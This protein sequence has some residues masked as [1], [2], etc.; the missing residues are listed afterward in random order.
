MFCD[1]KLPFSRTNG[2]KGGYMWCHPTPEHAG[3]GAPLS[4]LQNPDIICI[5]VWGP[6]QWDETHTCGGGMP[7]SHTSPMQGGLMHIN[8]PNQYS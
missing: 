8:E 4:L 7:I 2:P 5:Q 1:I 6:T 3:G